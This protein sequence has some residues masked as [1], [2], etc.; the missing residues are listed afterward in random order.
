MSTRTKS[1]AAAKKTT[2]AAPARKRGRKAAPKIGR[3]GFVEPSAKEVAR[4]E[5]ELDANVRRSLPKKKTTR[6]VI[7]LPEVIDAPTTNGTKPKAGKKLSSDE[8][9][10]AQAFDDWKTGAQISTLVTQTG[11]KRSRLRRELIVRAGGTAGF[12]AL[13]AK[14]AGG[15][16]E[17]FGG[18]RASGGSVPRAAVV[19]ANDKNVPIIAGMP[20]SKGWTTRRLWRPKIVTVKVNDEQKTMEAREQIG[21]VH[22]APDG[23]EYVECRTANENADI[24]VES[25]VTPGTYLRFRKFESSPVAK[26]VASHEKIVAQGETLLK[27]RRAKKRAVRETRKAAKHVTKKPARRTR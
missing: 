24:R 13:R 27:H 10:Y 8:A 12:K 18:K 17:A 11:L 3:D 7:E 21:E 2:K 14:G 20:R 25:R 4:R 16:A 1:K 5:R 6:V 26:K 9:K 19:A 23:V 15:S 22:I